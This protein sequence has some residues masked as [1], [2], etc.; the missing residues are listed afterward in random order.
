[1]SKLVN[2][3]VR[4]TLPYFAIAGLTVGILVVT[5]QLWKADLSIPLM[6]SSDGLW[7][8]AW[9][10]CVQ[11]HGWFLHNPDL[12][13]P[14]GSDLHDFPMAENVHFALIRLLAVVFRSPGFLFNFYCLL[15]FPLTACAALFVLRRIGIQDQLAAVA[16]LLFAFLPYHFWRAFGHPFLASY[17]LVPFQVLVTIHLAR[18]GFSQESGDST[19]LR[20][21]LTN[22]WPFLIGLCFLV[23]GAGVYYAFFGCFF[24]LAAGLCALLQRSDWRSLGRSSI[25]CAVTALFLALHLTPQLLYRWQQGKNDEAVT[26]PSS[27]AELY[28]LRV[29]QLLLPTLGHRVPAM[30][31]LARRYVDSGVVVT[32]NQTASLGLI[33]SACFLLLLAQ[34]PRCLA[35]PDARRATIDALALSNVAGLLLGGIGGFGCLFAFLFASWI[36]AYNR[37]SVFLA[38]FALAAAGLLIDPWLRRWQQRRGGAW[39]T[40]GL[41]VVLLT[42]GILD[43]FSPAFVPDY[44]SLEARYKQAAAF[45]NPIEAELPPGGMIFQLPFIA[46]PE[47]ISYDH[48][49]D[50]D[51][52][53]PYLVSKSLRWSY[54]SMRGRAGSSFA[55]GLSG[56]P[57]ERMVPALALAGFQGICVDRFAYDDRASRLELE[58]TRILHTFPRSDEGGRWGYFAL[59]DYGRTLRATLSPD[60]Y[61]RAAAELRQPVLPYFAAG[62]LIPEG[63]PADT[64]RWGASRA[65]IW[66]RNPCAEARTIVVEFE[67]DRLTPEPVHLEVEHPQGRVSV[68]IGYGRQ[69]IRFAT[70]VDP[71]LTKLFLTCDGIPVKDGQSSEKRIFRLWNLS[72]LPVDVP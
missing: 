59:A 12:G 30:N 65:E 69:R 27:D 5:L 18:G 64:F 46:F 61:D 57:P 2:R 66:L 23:G 60:V 55:Q 40:S 48:Y 22:S 24:Y 14:W 29:T 25:L 58:L 3:L 28:G 47:S 20:H 34:I 45:F 67:A 13:A 72:V 38:F 32:E 17:Y 8:Q 19:S 50:Y 52:L 7:V 42:V 11:D 68:Q 15:T 62:F 53:R 16:S 70:I 37:V 44:A 9:T 33:G 43:Q 54:G 63:P 26:R 39:L 49:H 1:M 41:L 51:H 6:D 36:R 21:D 56:L 4:A 35:R 31:D 10:R 71:A